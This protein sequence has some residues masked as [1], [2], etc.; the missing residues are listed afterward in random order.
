VIKPYRPIAC[1]LHDE[2]EIAIMHKTTLS[3]R[4]SDDTGVQHLAIILAK[5]ILVKD[6][7]EFLLAETQDGKELSIRLDK[8]T[9]LHDDAGE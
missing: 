7:Q 1:A 9:L 2:Y 8:I 5:D 3:I 4:W 6:K